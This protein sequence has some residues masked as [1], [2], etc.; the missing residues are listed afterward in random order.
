MLD[1]NEQIKKFGEFFEQNY[2]A[3]ILENIRKKE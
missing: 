1:A 3:E 2:N